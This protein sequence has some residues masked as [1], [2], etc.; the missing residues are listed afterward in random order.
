MASFFLCNFNGQDVD[1]KTVN[2]CM[3]LNA[4]QMSTVVCGKVKHTPRGWLSR[5]VTK[6]YIT[7]R[8]AAN[9]L[10]YQDMIK[11]LP[12]NGNDSYYFH[13]D[14]CLC[15]AFVI[16]PTF[17]SY[18]TEH[19]K[20]IHDITSDHRSQKYEE[21]TLS[22]HDELHR[23]NT[24]VKE[25]EQIL[26]GHQCDLIRLQNAIKEAGVQSAIIQKAIDAE[27]AFI[28]K[29][30][31]HMKEMIEGVINNKRKIETLEI[32]INQ[33]KGKLEESQTNRDAI[34]EALSK[35]QS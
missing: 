32:S 10:G 6:E 29:T 13:Y 4:K 28:Q 2:G 3:Y 18:L 30:E 22:L 15:Y 24:L 23:H 5:N 20:N 26:A 17:A 34:L 11:K 25:E 31:Q 19:F 35:H 1:T 16:H 7:S 33:K 21:F 14:I 12:Y 8:A 9:Q 27:K